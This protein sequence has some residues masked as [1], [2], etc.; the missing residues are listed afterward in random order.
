MKSQNKKTRQ[1]SSFAPVNTESQAAL[2]GPKAISKGDCLSSSIASKLTTAGCTTNR[3]SQH[4]GAKLLLE[5]YY[6]TKLEL[7]SKMPIIK[8]ALNPKETNLIKKLGDNLA[9][10]RN[11]NRK[12]VGTGI[13]LVPIKTDLSG[14]HTGLIIGGERKVKV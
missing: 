8:C 14:G 12:L 5:D 4:A 13:T 11:G 6:R 9:T 3:P 10:S 7:T 2:G 1:L